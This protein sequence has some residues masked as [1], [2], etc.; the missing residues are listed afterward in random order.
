MDELFSLYVHH[1]GHFI[2]I[3]NGRKYVGGTVNI[4][5]NCDPDKWSKIEIENICWDFGYKSVSRLWYKMP[6]VDQELA[7]FHLIVDDSDAM[8]LT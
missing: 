8:Y 4:I 2:D 3:E 7:D 5:D 6:G 1:G